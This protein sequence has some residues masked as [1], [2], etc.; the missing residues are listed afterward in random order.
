MLEFVWE[1]G[2]RVRELTLCV[3]EIYFRDSAF[4]RNF[5]RWKFANAERNE[6]LTITAIFNCLFRSVVNIEDTVLNNPR[7]ITDGYMHLR[8]VNNCTWCNFIESLTFFSRQFSAFSSFMSIFNSSLAKSV[9]C[10]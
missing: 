3:D 7:I 9:Q 1:L 8:N 2:S 10:G 6:F 4:K 5:W